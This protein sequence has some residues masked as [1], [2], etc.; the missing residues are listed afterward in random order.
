MQR[1]EV[2]VAVRPLQW[3]LGVEGLREK[4]LSRNIL[5]AVTSPRYPDEGGRT[6]FE[7]LSLISQTPQPNLP[8][9]SNV[10]N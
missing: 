9:Q 3:S 7:T 8:E 6:F 2:S 10:H 4:V 1:L 5:S